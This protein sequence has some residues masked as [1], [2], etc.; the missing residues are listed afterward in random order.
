MMY[1]W[2]S[3]LTG[4]AQPQT[5]AM[6]VADDVDHLKRVNKS[7]SEWITKLANKLW[8]Y[9]QE[10]VNSDRPEKHPTPVEQNLQIL[11][12]MTAD[13]IREY[14]NLVDNLYSILQKL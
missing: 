9:A 8:I 4:L 6:Q 10:N 1:E 5:L 13:N 3:Q 2:E 7:L 14:E 12:H 11:M